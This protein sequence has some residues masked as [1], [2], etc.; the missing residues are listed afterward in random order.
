MTDPTHA[1]DVQRETL[2]LAKRLIS[3][4][5]VTPADGAALDLI[6]ARLTHAGFHCERLDRDG[7]LGQPLDLADQGGAAGRV[8]VAALHQQ[9]QAL[10][11]AGIIA[12]SVVL[13]RPL[14]ALAFNESKARTLG[15]RPGLTHAALLALVDFGDEIPAELFQA[16][17]EVIAF[18]YRANGAMADKPDAD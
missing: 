9:G 4:P 2:D 5:S 14:M 1:A 8:G 15:L 18:V 16:V 3:C 12:A 17:A 7:P 13:H 10:A 6:A 11:A